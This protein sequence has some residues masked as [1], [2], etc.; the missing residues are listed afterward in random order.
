MRLIQDLLDQDLTKEEA[1]ELKSIRN[2]H[3]ELVGVATPLFLRL[4][5]IGQKTFFETCQLALDNLVVSP[6]ELE[7]LFGTLLD[8]C[9][10]W[11]KRFSY[12]TAPEPPFEKSE[13]EGFRTQPVKW[14]E[15]MQ[16]RTEI[17]IARVKEEASLPF[18]TTE[19][20][21]EQLTAKKDK[22][23]PDAWEEEYFLLGQYFR[24]MEN[25]IAHLKWQHEAGS[26]TVDLLKH[27]VHT[28][29]SL[30]KKML[31]NDPKLEPLLRAIRFKKEIE[32][33][34]S[35]VHEMLHHPR[36]RKIDQVEIGIEE[37]ALY[38]LDKLNN[39]YG[40][41]ELTDLRKL[42]F[43]DWSDIPKFLKDNPKFFAAFLEFEK[44]GS[45]VAQFRDFMKSNGPASLQD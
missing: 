38:F 19:Q 39:I 17:N 41:L 27:S 35:Q 22:L 37:P 5:W 10:E 18:F 34:M 7:A 28:E 42:G 20:L 36:F 32:A 2:Q 16:R 31:D 13:I 33:E 40:I 21:C 3:Y 29:S 15:E 45:S 30:W 25:H 11:K 24:A 1:L 44:T 23:K 9:E 8:D 4:G 6:K 14:L 12:T 26:L 43:N